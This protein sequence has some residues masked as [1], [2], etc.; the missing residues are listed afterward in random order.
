MRNLTLFGMLAL[1]A[2]AAFY[3]IQTTS[4]AA[5]P[6]SIV[7]NGNTYYV[8]DGNNT[9]L[10]SGNEVCAAVGK[11]FNSYKSINTNGVCKALHPN[12]KEVTSVNGSKAGFYCNG[13]P[14][15]GLAC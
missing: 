15:T 11:K 1:C 4:A 2:A 14:L 10:D 8:V 5:T 12:A 3:S 7:F 9:A 13:L 6:R